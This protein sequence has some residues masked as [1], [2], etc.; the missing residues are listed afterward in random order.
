[1]AAGLEN[2]FIDQRITVSSQ[3][4]VMSDLAKAGAIDDVRNSITSI[5]V[6]NDVSLGGLNAPESTYNPFVMA[7]EVV[8]KYQLDG[9]LF[10]TSSANAGNLNVEQ[11]IDDERLAETVKAVRVRYRTL[12][13]SAD[14][15]EQLQLLLL[16]GEKAGLRRTTLI[17]DVEPAVLVGMSFNEKVAFYRKQITTIKALAYPKRELA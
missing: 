6:E 3:T 17:L 4:D 11:V 9:M 5:L 7:N 2:H 15:V 10:D 12:K 14:I 8:Q 16:L 1:L 13:T